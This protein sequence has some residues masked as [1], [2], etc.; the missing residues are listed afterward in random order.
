MPYKNKNDPRAIECSWKA[1]KKYRDNNRE[2]I[3]K[4][5]RIHDKKR[6]WQRRD[7]QRKHVLECKHTLKFSVMAIY[8]EGQP[9]CSCCGETAIEFLTIDHIAQN[10]AEHRKTLPRNSR[11]GYGFYC[12]LKKNGY[13]EGYGVLCL[14][15]NFSL[16][17]FG[18]CP[19]E[20]KSVNVKSEQTLNTTDK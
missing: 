14:N 3:R 20:W 7:Y 15:C 16:G 18:Y 6:Y 19:H 4:R 9:K 13:P 5:G 1:Q 11:T 8:S 17:H 2:E 12:W 10:G